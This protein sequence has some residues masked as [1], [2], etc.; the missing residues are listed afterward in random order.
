GY[1]GTVEATTIYTLT[2]NNELRVEMRA[3]T[4]KTTL[5]NMAHH[6]YWNL[7]GHASGTILDHELTLMAESYTPAV[8]LVPDGKVKPV[9]GTPFDFTSP[10]LIGADVQAAGGTPIGFD[11]NWI[12]DG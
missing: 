8:A 11:H 12:V 4:D 5:V 7:G 3:S 1:P 2:N 9:K 6:S 10:K